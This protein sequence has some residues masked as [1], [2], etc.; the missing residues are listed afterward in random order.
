[1]KEFRATAEVK[2]ECLVIQ[3]H[4]FQEGE[5]VEVTVTPREHKKSSRHPLHGEKIEYTDPFEPVALD[6]WE[7]LK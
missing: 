7:V 5:F 6:D 2:G 1:M 4:P 3:D